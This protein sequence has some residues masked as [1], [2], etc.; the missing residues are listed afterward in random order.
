[1]ES[2]ADLS[3]G[4]EFNSKIYLLPSGMCDGAGTFVPVDGV[5]ALAGPAQSGPARLASTV[6]VQSGI[7]GCANAHV[8]TFVTGFLLTIIMGTISHQSTFTRVGG[9]DQFV[10]NNQKDLVVRWSLLCAW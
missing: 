3:E 9:F 4:V 10:I 8:T 7:T 6:T 1:M 5:G 2:H